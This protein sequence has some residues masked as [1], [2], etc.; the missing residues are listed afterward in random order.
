MLQNVKFSIDFYAAGSSTVNS[1]WKIKLR[2][3]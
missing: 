2:Q 1:V 3:M